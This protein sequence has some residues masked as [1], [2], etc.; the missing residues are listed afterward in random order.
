[1]DEPAYV[2]CDHRG[3]LEHGPPPATLTTLLSPFDSL[4]WDRERNLALWGFEYK[5][6][7]YTPAAKRRYGYFTLPILWRDT[8]VGRVDA[9][10][11]RKAGIFRVKALHLEPGVPLTDELL[12]DLAWALR[13]CAAWHRTPQVV[14]DITD[15][16]ELRAALEPRLAD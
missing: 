14:I 5:I 2:H 7:C 15:P 9:K 4:V 1:W 11:E 12:A 3:W 16:P 13:D 8:L 6:E 10:A